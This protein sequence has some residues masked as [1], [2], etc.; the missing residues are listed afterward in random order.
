MDISKILQTAF[1][2]YL[3]AAWFAVPI[4]CGGGEGRCMPVK[5]IQSRFYCMKF[6]HKKAY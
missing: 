1:K 6:Y 5:S 2:S 4:G 3:R